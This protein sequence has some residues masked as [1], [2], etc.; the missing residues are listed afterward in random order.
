M[1]FLVSRVSNWVVVRLFKMTFPKSVC[2][3][4]QPLTSAYP[5]VFFFLKRLTAL[6]SKYGCTRT[7]TVNR[8]SLFYCYYYIFK[9]SRCSLLKIFENAHGYPP[10]QI[11]SHHSKTFDLCMKLLLQK[12]DDKRF[13]FD[14]IFDTTYLHI[15]ASVLLKFFM[16]WAANVA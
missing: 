6:L 14:F 9:L 8:G 3:L 10:H 5:S 7:I 4:F 11:L 16:N 1:H 12:K 15:S 13:F 2:I